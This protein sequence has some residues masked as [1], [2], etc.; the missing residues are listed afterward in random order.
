M[1]EDEIQLLRQ[2]KE[3]QLRMELMHQHLVEQ[4][5]EHHT[6]L[7]HPDHGVIG[8]QRDMKSSMKT[9]T[10]LLGLVVPTATALVVF[11]VQT[12]A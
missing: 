8:Q 2:I 9:V 7:F 3:S 11:I 12:L 5:G 10:W 6:A 4:V 1:T